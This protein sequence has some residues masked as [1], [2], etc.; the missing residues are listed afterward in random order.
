MKFNFSLILIIIN[1]SLLNSQYTETINSNR[2]GSSNGAFA[3]GKKVIQ[4]EIGLKKHEK[5]YSNYNNLIND[6]SYSL[7]Y[8]FL[9]NKL[10]LFLNGSFIE[11]KIHSDLS[12][13]INTESIFA[14]QK[15]GFKYLIYDPFKNK[16]WH[17]VNLY[18]W[19]KNRTI[20]FVDFIPA[21]SAFFA[22]N[23]MPKNSLNDN[24][25]Y[26]LFEH[27]YYKYNQNTFTP[28]FGISTQNHFL[29]KWVLVNQF[30]IDK[31]GRSSKVFSHTGT[32]IHNFKN[33]RWSAFIEHQLNKL[34]PAILKNDI[35]IDNYFKFGG[36][37]LLNK[38][39][40][41]DS[42]IEFESNSSNNFN[43]NFGFSTR[44]DRY[45][46]DIKIDNDELKA[47][48]KERRKNRKSI[49]KDYK[50]AEKQDKINKRFDRKERKLIKKINRKNKK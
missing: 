50:L 49:K 14:N 45:V 13:Y 21:I 19:K 1:F 38:N 32:L 47:N 39:F 33:P 36:A 5:T 25:N 16:K 34:N 9:S 48:K 8:G 17:S 7:R 24:F 46:D 27:S 22:V 29:G 44:I 11:N 42:S 20:R 37:F 43:I 28:M 12:G 6:Y 41:F 10:E 15:L 26:W 18:S 31:V 30:A 40:Q 35:Y 4:F 23:Y 2:P 3:V